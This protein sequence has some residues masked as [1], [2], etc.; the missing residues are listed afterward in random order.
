MKPNSHKRLTSKAPLLLLL[1]MLLLLNGVVHAEGGCPPGLIPASGTDINSCVPIP[2]GYYTQT[3]APQPPQWADR[4][5][6]VATDSIRGSLG[7]AT[8]MPSR[9]NAERAAIADCQAKGGTQCKLDVSYGNGC[10]AMIVGDGGYNSNGA[11][12]VDEAVQL[13][14]KI[15]ANAGHANCH[16]YYSVC[17]L[18][19]RIQ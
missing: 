1:G 12:T 5:L 6:A 11:A 19:Q 7:T 10:A 14:M 9:G 2:P 4:W 13:G 17:S 15:C 18:P 8:G 16:V 3:A